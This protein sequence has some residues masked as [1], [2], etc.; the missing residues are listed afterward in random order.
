MTACPSP[1]GPGAAVLPP[2]TLLDARL[3]L[4]QRWPGS[5]APEAELAVFYRHAT[6]IYADAA[7]RD[8]R[9]REEAAWWARECQ[10][11]AERYT[12]HDQQH[13]T[14]PTTDRN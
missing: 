9:H 11:R 7:R 5:H 12:T 1:D 6:G 8:T 2:R 3:Y 13:T 4:A 14:T 10:R